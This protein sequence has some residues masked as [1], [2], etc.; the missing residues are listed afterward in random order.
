MQLVELI[1]KNGG[2]PPQNFALLDMIP[3][4]VVLFSPNHKYL[5]INAGAIANEERRAWLIGKDDFDYC[6]QYNKPVKLAE[7][8]RRYFEQAIK[9]KRPIQF[10]ETYNGEEPARYSV[11]A[12][13]PILDANGEVSLVLGYGYNDTE[14]I[15]SLRQL[16]QIKKALDNSSDGIAVLNSDGVY[17]YM[18]QAHATIFEYDSP[19]ELVGKTW[20]I[21]YTQENAEL[22]RTQ[23]MPQLFANGFWKGPTVGKSKHGKEIYQDISLSTLEDNGL[24]CITRDQ[25]ELRHILQETK[26]LAVVTEKTKGLVAI[27]DSDFHIIWANDSFYDKTGYQATQIV[28]CPFANLISGEL[29]DDHSYEVIVDTLHKTGE[30]QGKVCMIR[31]DQSPFWMLLNITTVYNDQGDIENYVIIQLDFNELHAVEQKLY[32]SA[33]KERNLSL[34]K[35]KFINVTS[36]EIR[37]PL[38]NI[39]LFTELIRQKGNPSDTTLGLLEKI[40]AQV[41]SITRIMDE[42][43]V[44]SKANAG[45]VNIQISPVDLPVMLQSI[46]DNGIIA[47][48]HHR[49]KLLIKGESRYVKTDP[50]ILQIVIKNLLENSLKYSPP[51]TQVE[52]NLSYLESHIRITVRD[53]GIGIPEEAFDKLFD[54]FYRA[55]NAEFIKGSGLGLTIVKEF[56]DLLGGSISFTSKLKTGTTFTVTLPYDQ[57]STH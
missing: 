17:T 16:D 13:N 46:L 19:T 24:I 40:S 57:N 29:N 34:I 21:I 4:D 15:R 1:E 14:R 52:L 8:R 35:S 18:N 25:T 6:R 38:A 50:T 28:T 2:V 23:Y 49:V 53:S 30:F 11:R 32:I 54:S 37:T 31:K 10:V 55:N 7:N 41:K 27:A 9:E 44:L 48:P 42:F 20:D 5:F 33:L 3:A 36:H 26:R 22:I 45:N 56:L 43:L 12:F 39:E 51:Q 47:D